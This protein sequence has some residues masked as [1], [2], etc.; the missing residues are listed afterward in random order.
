[1]TTPLSEHEQYPQRKLTE[2]ELGRRGRRCKDCATLRDAG[3]Y[4]TQ[5]RKL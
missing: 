2:P 1:M 4:T 3:K 5:S